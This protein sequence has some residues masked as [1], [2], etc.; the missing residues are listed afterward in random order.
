[1]IDKNNIPGHVAIIMDGNGRWARQ[2]SLPRTEGHREGIKRAEEIVEAA[3]DLGI[4][5]VTFFAF[6][7]ENWLRPKLEVKTL[8]RLMDIF[9]KQN[10]KKL[11]E[12]N[13]RLLVIGRRELVPDYLWRNMAQVQGKTKG[14]NGLTL[15]L[16]FNY[17]SRQEILD[18]VKKIIED[19]VKPED[20]SQEKF[21]TFL[22]TAGIPDPDLLIRTSGELRISNFL[23]WQLSYSELYF[24]PVCW[25]D[26]KRSNFEE[27]IA[28]YQ[29]R[30]RRFGS[31]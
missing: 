1:M 4:K 2:R 29:N 18:A 24:S 16:A 10:L 6:S 3:N 25:P 30:L 9:L 12:N 7:A 11:M 26:F 22:Y 15:V 21:G 17:G 20:L 23:L 5:F 19:K 8:M 31:I 13:M 14:N 28:I 27:A